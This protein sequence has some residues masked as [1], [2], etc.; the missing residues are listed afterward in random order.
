MKIKYRTSE[1]TTETIQKGGVTF[2]RYRIFEGKNI[3]NAVSTRLG[4]VSTGYVGTMNMSTTR[5]DDPEN[6]EKNHALF[7]GAAGYDPEKLVMSDQV[8]DTKIL[9]VDSKDA[10]G[11]VIQRGIDG[12]MTDVANIPLMTFYADCVPLMFYDE[13][14]HV[15]AMS[16]SGWKGTVAKIGKITL[17]RMKEEYGTEPEDVYAAI[18]PSVCQSCY[19]VD[20][21]LLT[22]FRNAFGKKADEW[23]AASVNP[24]HYMLDL[25]SACC[26]TLESAGMKKDH[27]AMP[28]LCTCCNPDFLFS[29]RATGGKRGNISVVMQL[30]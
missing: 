22:S 1:R 14:N 27:I 30:L 4:G 24:D 5:G 8:H 11:G 29:H 16:H 20:E 6:V 28:D 9:R 23:F 12:L 10:G 25:A 17:E 2:L 7:A 26:Y 3:I 19:E 15:I 13:K 21:T 18:G